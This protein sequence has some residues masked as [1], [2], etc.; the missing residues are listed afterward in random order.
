MGGFKTRQTIDMI[1]S[2]NLKQIR[3]F[4]GIAKIEID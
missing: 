3:A 4:D 2:L 1:Q